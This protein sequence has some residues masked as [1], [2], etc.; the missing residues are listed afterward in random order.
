M[1]YAGATARLRAA[2]A[3]VYHPRMSASRLVSCVAS[4]LVAGACGNRSFTFDNLSLGPTCPRAALAG[5]LDGC[6]GGT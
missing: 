4:G 2:G 5:S 1:E 6:A 3:P